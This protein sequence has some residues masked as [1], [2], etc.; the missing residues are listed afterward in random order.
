LTSRMRMC[1]ES[2]ICIVDCKLVLTGLRNGERYFCPTPP[3]FFSV[4]CSH[5]SL[6]A[7]DGLL[8][9]G[10]FCNSVAFELVMPS[11]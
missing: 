11:I 4:L 7:G 2:A 6:Y 5:W 10:R 1:F 9:Y 8:P 3:S